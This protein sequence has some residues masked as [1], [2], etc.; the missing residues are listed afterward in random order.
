LDIVDKS[1]VSN[2]HP[3]K[4]KLVEKYYFFLRRQKWATS[5]GAATGRFRRRVCELDGLENANLNWTLKLVAPELPFFICSL[6]T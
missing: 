3:S 5:A 6:L 1:I 4:R 2:I